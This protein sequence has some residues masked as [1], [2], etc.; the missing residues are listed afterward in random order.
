MRREINKL[1]HVVSTNIDHIQ[2]N[3]VIYNEL[4]FDSSNS[5][6][7]NPV[8]DTLPI[9]TIILI[10]GKHYRNNLNSV[11]TCLWDSRDTGSMINLKHINPYNPK[12]RSYKVDYIIYFGPYRTTH[13]VKVPFIMPDFP[14]RKTITHRVHIDKVIVYE[15]IGYVMI[16]F[17]DLMIQ[18]GLKAGF[19]HQVK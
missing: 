14:I 19:S 3:D 8:K 7:N 10:G 18:L 2:V 15:G 9:V 5:L 12:L 17:H 4:K 1:D 16:I 13:D 6:S 11:I